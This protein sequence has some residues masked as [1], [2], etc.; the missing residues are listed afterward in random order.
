MNG[1]ERFISAF[2]KGG[3]PEIP[4]CINYEHI[5]IRDHWTV[6]TE[7]PWWQIFSPYDEDK[8]TW[9]E[10]IS[11]KINQDWVVVPIGLSE[12]GKENT[13]IRKNGKSFSIINDLTKEEI[14]FHRND[15]I[16]DKCVGPLKVDNKKFVETHDELELWFDKFCNI[17]KSIEVEN[18][19]VTAYFYKPVNRV[20]KEGFNSLPLK[21]NANWGKH[22]FP[23]HY[24]RDPVFLAYRIWGIEGMI[25]KMVDNPSIF[26]HACELFT[27]YCINL[28]DMLAK[29]KVSAIYIACNL[30]GMINNEDFK[31]Y[32]LPYLQR[33][34]EKAKE[35][36]I[37]VIVN[38]FGDIKN[39]WDIILRC[40]ADGLSFEEGKNGFTDRNIDE[41][42]EKIK[43]KYVLFGNIDPISVLE[44]GKLADLKDQIRLQIKSGRKNNS[45]F[46]V[47]LGGP[48]TPKTDIRRVRKFIEIVRQEN[49]QK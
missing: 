17:E 29:I 25:I 41:I 46:V 43:G 9:Q 22:L 42:V 36:N 13:I 5:Y 12:K 7:K 23:I 15:V 39:K 2:S 19:T 38:F 49:G 34:C 48:I 3:T 45:R 21:I 8:Y 18:D 11:R 44:K 47:S 6:L 28:I 35:N 40:N 4:V 20:G 37:K 27:K 31:K 33:I 16:G 26:K 10:E 14:R 32:N 1:K 24:V 30:I